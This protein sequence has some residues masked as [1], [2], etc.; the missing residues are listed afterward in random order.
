MYPYTPR[1][2]IGTQ[3]QPM[4]SSGLPGEG[5]RNTL[6]SIA[7]QSNPVVDELPPGPLDCD[8][9]SQHAVASII[10]QW[11]P[12]E[13]TPMEAS[14]GNG[15]PSESTK[16]QQERAAP[17]TG[18]SIAAYITDQ[19]SSAGHQPSEAALLLPDHR[20]RHHQST[21]IAF[22][23]PAT[24]KQPPS[25][26]SLSNADSSGLP[27]TQS[28]FATAIPGNW[29]SA[30]RCINALLNSECHS[31]LPQPLSRPYDLTGCTKYRIEN[32]SSFVRIRFFDPA[33]GDFGGEGGNSYDHIPK[34]LWWGLCGWYSI[35]LPRNHLRAR[36]QPQ[37]IVGTSVLSHGEPHTVQGPFAEQS[38]DSTV[39]NAP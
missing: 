38:A 26:T 11:W 7:L 17:I 15:W 36:P 5:Q 14:Y 16:V 29:V 6:H 2:S 30:G 9:S 10:L 35:S 20:H 37:L 8:D 27:A 32:A 3:W 39:N 31:R 4:D 22:D 28:S 19:F 25:S 23:A 1:H 21:F 12:A 24:S 34:Q 33:G 13:Q 18:V